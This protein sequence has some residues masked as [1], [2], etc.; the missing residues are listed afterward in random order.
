[1]KELLGLIAVVLTIIG[2][3]PYIVDTLK[4]KTTP[5]LFT[6]II[7]AIVAI[8]AF[9]GQWQKGG[10]AGS[11]TT[12]VTGLITIFIA[13]LSLKNGT[14]DITFSDKIF[15]IAALLSIIPWYLT[16]DPT[17]SIICLTLIDTLAFAPTIRKT[18]KNPNSETLFTYALNILRHGL[19][20][21]AL[22]NYNVATYLYPLSLLIMNALMTIVIIRPRL[23]KFH[24]IV[25]R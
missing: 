15:F 23:N 6:W 7:W 14:K 4:K 5:H 19:S 1:M 25:K 17:I 21:L 20:L 13:I 9:L 16:K 2:H 22:A 11:W 18:I 12:G 24:K 3:F 10:G 8:L